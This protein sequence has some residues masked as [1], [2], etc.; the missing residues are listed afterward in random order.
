MRNPSKKRSQEKQP[1]RNCSRLEQTRRQPATGAVLIGSANPKETISVSIHIRRRLDGPPIPDL[2]YWQN[3]P[4]GRR[5]FL[6]VTEFTQKYGA[7]PQDLHKVEKFATS[8]GLKVVKTNAAHRIIIVSGTVSQM[9]SA[10]AVDLGLY[11][12]PWPFPSHRPEKD[13]VPAPKT[14]RYRGRMAACTCPRTLP[15]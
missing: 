12:S 5:K 13:H 15:R 1:P 3:H 8:H 14:Y 10:F 7:A 11:E 4:P 6:S 2:K 9:Q